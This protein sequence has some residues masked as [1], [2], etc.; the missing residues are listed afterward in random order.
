MSD[1]L[2]F[3]AMTKRYGAVTVLDDVSITLAPGRV[4]ALMGENGAGKSTLIKLIAGVLPA[5]AMTVRKGGSICQLSSPADAAALGFRFIHQELNVVSQLS[6]AEN[7]LLSHRVPE[8]FGLFV[9]W[10]AMARRAGEALHRLG[11]HHIDP[12]AH[13]GAL[14]TGDQMLVKLASALV[15]D[16]AV[17]PLLYVLDEPTAALKDAEVAKLFEVVRSLKDAGA[18]ILYV[19]H[20]ISEITTIC[21]DVTVLRNGRHISTHAV[22]DTGR[23]RIIKD[24]TGKDVD[25]DERAFNASGASSGRKTGVVAQLERVGA[26]RLSGID[27]TLR[28]GEV[29]GV[30]GL[31]DAGQTALLR[32]FLGLERTTFGTAQFLDG[33]LPQSPQAAWARGVAYVPQER[34]TEGLMMAMGVRPNALLPHLDG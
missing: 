22:I 21:D 15:A 23:A 29:V 30:A 20:R 17:P 2:H 27:L 18:A 19:S 4:H 10:V 5:D 3:E 24:M 32:L 7:I 13:A 11:V 31:S 25:A 33:P 26:R 1:P 34:R 9:D 16:E 8:R 12:R 28:E 14:G 6:V